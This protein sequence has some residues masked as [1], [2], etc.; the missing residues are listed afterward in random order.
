MKGEKRLAAGL[1]DDSAV[2]ERILG[3]IRNRTTDMGAKV[4]REPVDNYCSEKRFAAELKMLRRSTTPFC[5]S[6]ALPEKGSYVAREAA[7]VPILVARGEDGKVRAFRNACRHRGMQVATGSRHTFAPMS[8]VRLRMWPRM[9]S[10]TAL[11]SSRP[12]LPCMLHSNSFLRYLD[13]SNDA[14]AKGKA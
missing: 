14:I 6:A 3:H 7:G 2:V 10:T 13:V 8:V 1:L 11:S 4:W 9:R 5:P 12:F